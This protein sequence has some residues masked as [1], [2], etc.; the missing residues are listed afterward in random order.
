MEGSKRTKK[1]AYLAAWTLALM[2]TMLTPVLAGGKKKASPGKIREFRVLKVAHKK[3]FLRWSMNKGVSGYQVF[4]Q[5]SE[6]GQF[7]LVKQ[8]GA[9]KN[10]ALITGLKNGENYNF[11][12]R[13]FIK[14]NGKF[15]YGPMSRT[16]VGRPVSKKEQKLT[17]AIHPYYYKAKMNKTVTA[18]G[19]K[20]ASGKAVTVTELGKSKSTVRYK[21]QDLE[22]PTSALKLLGFITKG[23]K[24]YSKSEAESFVNMKGYQSETGYLIWIST[25]TQRIY[26]F[27]GKQYAWTL[28]KSS[29]CATG[30]L[31]YSTPLGVSQVHN[32]QKVVE[33]PGT[34]NQG[35]YY[36]FR[37]LGGYIHSW[38][39]N[40]AT[41]SLWNKPV[42]GKPTSHGCVRTDIKFA[43][44]MFETV[45]VNTT[46]VTY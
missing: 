44:W 33:F 41:G 11:K 2:M 30:R 19:V 31:E 46:N 37:I 14:K 15:T 38:L 34:N 26:V 39:Y 23:S 10:I 28:L 22:V 29:P 20:L 25:Y 13:A 21:K 32:K 5:N 24:T 36:G 12:V 42:Y 40:I 7:E 43:K 18:D 17:S 1:W 27:E 35:G 45:P 9:S 8:V 6:T 16:V 4:K 3:V